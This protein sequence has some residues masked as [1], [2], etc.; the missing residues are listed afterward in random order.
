M[1]LVLLFN[2]VVTFVVFTWLAV[3]SIIWV[4]S[5]RRQ[6]RFPSY[7]P[8]I[9]VIVPAYNEEQTIETCISRIKKSDYRGKIEVVV[10]SDGSTD[11]T[12]TLARKAGAKVIRQQRAGKARAMNRAVKAA[13][14]NTL[15]TIDADTF[16]EKNTLAHLV[17]PL[18]K[19]SIGSTTG[20]VKVKLKGI[21]SYFQAVE[22]LQNHLIRT[23]FTRVFGAGI[24][25]FGSLAAFKREALHKAGYFSPDTLAED[26]DVALA[27]EREGYRTYVADAHAETIVPKSVPALITQ[28]RRWWPGTLHAL[29]KHRP[30][31]KGRK[32]VT[33]LVMNQ[34]MWSIHSGLTLPLLLYQMLFWLPELSPYLIQYAVQW[35]SLLGPTLVATNIP[36]NGISF[37]NIFGIASGF[38]GAWIGLM[39][40][41]RFKQIKWQYLLV[42]FFYFPYTILINFA[43]FLSLYFPQKHRR[44]RQ[45]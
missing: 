34:W 21:L 43:I 20:I 29:E 7:Q 6:H 19:K 24:W 23:T 9:S 42:I 13:R 1:N 39:A 11:S 35:F 27:L 30:H 12:V 26:M 40:L 10:V 33:F 25:F 15:A 38:L 4:F 17:A 36:A 22:Y 5:L 28:R 2:A 14:Y 18:Q 44:Q 16:I 32:H 3:M 31:I 37:L 45:R 8:D 41:I